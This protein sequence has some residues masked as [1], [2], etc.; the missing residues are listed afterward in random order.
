MLSVKGKVANHD[1]SVPLNYRFR[2]AFAWLAKPKGNHNVD[3]WLSKCSYYRFDNSS[4]H[5]KTSLKPRSKMNIL[6]NL[7]YIF[8]IAAQELSRQ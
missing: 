2:K 5:N 1:C 4:A 6:L 8:A 7:D 3:T